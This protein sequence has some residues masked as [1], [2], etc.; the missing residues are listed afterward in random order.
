MANQSIT[1]AEPTAVRP[2]LS[3]PQNFGW[4]LGGSLIYA[5]CQWGMIVAFAKFGNTVMVGQ[6]SL[7]LAIATPILMF[8]NL[9]LR[10]VQA[11]DASGQYSFP[12]YFSLRGTMTLLAMVII[13]AV[14]LIGN[15]ERATTKVVLAV[16]CAKCLEAVS[17]VIYGLFQSKDRLD[18]I[19]KSQMLRGTLSVSAL[20]LTLYLTKDPFPSVEALAAAW[21]LVLL[22]FDVRR[23]RR[24]ADGAGANPMAWLRSRS[25]QWFGRQWR[26]ASLSLPLG[27]V[28]TLYAFNQS[29]PRYFIQAR[30]GEHE[31]G[32]FSALSYTTVGVTLVAD[33]LGATATPRLSRLYAAA[34]LARFRVLMARLLGIGVCL[35]VSGWLV[36]KYAGALLLAMFYNSEYS[37][38][39]DL[40]VRLMIASGVS[41][42]ASLLTYGITAARNFRIQVPMYALVLAS[43]AV[44]CALWVPTSGL[45]GAASAVMLASFVQLAAA[46]AAAAWVFFPSAKGVQTQSPEYD[47]TVSL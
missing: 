21:L 24:F 28:M 46:C 3:M 16:G 35:S 40:F 33:A 14:A 11:T 38:H 30:F 12:E 2:G 25:R 47:Y 41:L 5:A 20:A 36:A 32:I 4:A 34:K 15:H 37:A 43:N 42:V 18:Q 13:T 31:L 23:A 39:A 26:L 27:I 22:T 29:M 1:A 7:G 10:W 44:G 19:G 9:Q 6:F 45:A 8:T 17:D